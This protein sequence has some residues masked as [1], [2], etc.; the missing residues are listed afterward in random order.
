M[1]LKYHEITVIIIIASNLTIKNVLDLR[2]TVAKI[3]YNT[4]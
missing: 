4:Q 3:N 2:V 1:R